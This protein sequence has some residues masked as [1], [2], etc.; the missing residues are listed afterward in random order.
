M[1]DVA[2]CRGASDGAGA[3]VDATPQQLK[4]CRVCCAA[5]CG[6]VSTCGGASDGAGPVVDATPAAAQGVS[7]VLCCCVLWRQAAML[8]DWKSSDIQTDKVFREMANHQLGPFLQVRQARQHVVKKRLPFSS[9]L[10]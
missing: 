4:T 1:T 7:G 8:D 3:V 6:D 10:G 9:A 2:T 5:C